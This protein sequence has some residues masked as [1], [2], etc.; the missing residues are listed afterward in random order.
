M[1]RSAHSHSHPVSQ[2]AKANRASQRRLDRLR[3]LGLMTPERQAA[4][5]EEARAARRAEQQRATEPSDVS[6]LFPSQEREG[7]HASAR[8]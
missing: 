5:V 4:L 3:H 8:C 6:A 2:A 1:A 7:T